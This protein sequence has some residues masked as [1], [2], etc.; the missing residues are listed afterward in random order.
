MSSHLHIQAAQLR[1]A[2]KSQEALPLY[3]SALLEYVAEKDY[4]GAVRVLLETSI[5][6]RH[7]FYLE[8]DENY[9]I[10]GE[11]FATTALALCEAHQ[12]DQSVISLAYQE[13]GTYAL[14][15][16]SAD[17]AVELYE[18]AVEMLD[19]RDQK[20]NAQAHLAAAYW[21]NGQKQEALR[22]FGESIAALQSYVDQPDTQA[23]RTWLSGALMR[24]ARCFLE[25][26]NREKA[27]E[28]VQAAQ[29]IL[30]SE[31]K[32]PVRERQLAEL[33]KLLAA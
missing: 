15:R 13:L 22:L 14:L 30:Q 29:H 21:E 18:E 10:M 32:L 16:D 4:E 2:G 27:Q 28:N 23:H 7:L 9:L 11:S 1:E 26:E 24:R 12:L 5:V 19:P 6:Y 33:K 25:D 8:Q 31:P 20:A 17:E 3:T